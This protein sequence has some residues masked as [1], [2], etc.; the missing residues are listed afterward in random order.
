VDTPEAA[1]H[2]ERMLRRWAILTAPALLLGWGAGA[3]AQT[4]PSRPVEVH[5]T[6]ATHQVVAGHQITGTVTLTNTSDH[7]ITVNTCATNGWLAVGLSGHGTSPPF[8]HTA[9]GCAPS[10]RLSPGTH[11]F[12]VTVI[13]TY[14]TCQEP[15]PAGNP[16]SALPT[17]TVSNGR[18]TAPPLPAGTYSTQM[19]F[20]GLNGKTTPPNHVA[21]T[22]LAPAKPPVLAPCA[23]VP[24]AATPTVTV[25]NVVGLSSSLAALSFAHA[26]INAGWTSPVGTH[27]TAEAPVAGAKV[28]EHSTVMLTT[29]GTA[30]TVP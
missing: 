14:G 30:G 19:Q 11:H 9:V 12:P 5:L 15:E 6:L 10:V 17:C 20:V 27:V 29:Q 21:V 23:D 7:S 4:A 16:P 26:C 18:Q 25:P 13:T 8:F 22:L 2:N 28:P 1:H 3:A 24:G